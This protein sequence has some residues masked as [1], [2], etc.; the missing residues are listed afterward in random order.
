MT[1]DERPTGSI[2]TRTSDKQKTTRGRRTSDDRDQIVDTGK[3]TRAAIQSVLT[4]PGLTSG[5]LRVFLAILHET[6]TWTRVWDRRSV[7]DLAGLAGVSIRTVHR[8][9]RRLQDVGAV[10]WHGSRAAEQLSEVRLATESGTTTVQ[11]DDAH[12]PTGGTSH[13][14]TGGTTRNEKPLREERGGHA[15]D[16]G[17]DEQ[18]RAAAIELLAEAT[19]KYGVTLEALEADANYGGLLREIAHRLGNDWSRGELAQR[20]TFMRLPDRVVSLAAVFAAR[21]DQDPQSM[22]RQSGGRNGRAVNRPGQPGEFGGTSQHLTGWGDEPIQ[23]VYARA[24]SRFVSEHNQ[25]PS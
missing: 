9:L 13:V 11:S 24:D 15:S 6:S 4:T 21:L 18:H 7:D 20:L 5:E 12:M 17:G 22:P 2:M 10:E 8:A 19:R 3:A 23:D 16:P 25:I 1:N 14:T